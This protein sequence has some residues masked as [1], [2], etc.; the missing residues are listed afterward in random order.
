MPQDQKFRN[1]FLPPEKDWVFIDSDLSSAEVCILAHAA[2]ESVFLDAV[3]TGKDLHLMSASLVFENEWISLAEPGCTHLID[4]SKCD[5]PGHN[6]KRKFSKAI[7]FGLS[8][9]LGPQG[10]SERLDIT[11]KEA[12][13]LITKFFKAFPKLQAFLDS[14]ADFGVQNLYLRSLSPTKRIRFFEHPQHESDKSAIGRASRNFKI[15]ETNASMIKIA[16]VNLRSIIIKNNY[17]VKLHLP[18]H[19]EIL[20]S[21]HKDFAEQWKVIQEREMKKAADL[22]LEPGL[23]GVDTVIID[24]WT[25]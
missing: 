20:A 2:G 12:E 19:D 3:K 16:L 10:L 18:V 17:P 13:D 24:K 5:C 9:G 1:A 6:K 15:Q 25:K 22:F 7:T 14:S 8:Y 11:R 23:L 21:A 4:G